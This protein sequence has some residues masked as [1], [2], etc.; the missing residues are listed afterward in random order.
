MV[1]LLFCTE[2]REKRKT[3]TGDDLLWAM[4]TLGFDSYI[5]PLKIYLNRYRQAMIHDKIDVKGQ[6]KPYES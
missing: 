4:G 5:D 6:V 1:C 3:I 2:Q